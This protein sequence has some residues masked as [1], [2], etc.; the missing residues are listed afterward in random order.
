MVKKRKEITRKTTKL[1]NKR[2]RE[3]TVG[4]REGRGRCREKEEE[5]K[6]EEEEEG[7]NCRRRKHSPL[8]L[9]SSLRSQTV[10]SDFPQFVPQIFHFL[11]S[12]I[13]QFCDSLTIGQ[14]KEES[15]RMNILC[16]TSK[17]SGVEQSQN[18]WKKVRKMKK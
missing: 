14:W 11:N 18:L 12:T 13:P 2:E 16:S 8:S 7:C 6:K 3:V 1:G 10:P 15:R 9:P 17:R 5:E 4:W